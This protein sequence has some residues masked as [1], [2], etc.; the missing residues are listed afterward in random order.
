M[1]RWGAIK[2]TLGIVQASGSL[3]CTHVDQSG[4]LRFDPSGLPTAWLVCDRC[5]RTI[6]FL[7]H[8]TAEVQQQ[9]SWPR[10]A[11]AGAGARYFREEGAWTEREEA[12]YERAHLPVAAK[13]APVEPSITC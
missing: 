7:P 9:R 10:I 8:Q 13:A 12:T 3:V 11:T 1:E 6:A 4:Q 5:G 2:R